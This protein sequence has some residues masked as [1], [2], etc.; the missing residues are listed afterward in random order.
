ML[1]HDE[2]MPEM[3]TIYQLAS[4]IK[5]KLEN[6]ALD[7][8]ERDKLTSILED[9]ERSGDGMMKWMNELNVL[10]E[11][12]SDSLTHEEIMASLRKDEAKVIAVSQAMRQS[13]AEAEAALGSTDE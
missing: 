5:E 9:L 3:N 13:I 4:R 1:A 8:A 2:V 12:R 10:P 7:T 6:S 11:L